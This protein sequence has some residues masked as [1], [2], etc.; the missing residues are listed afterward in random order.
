MRNPKLLSLLRQGCVVQ[1]PLRIRMA[2]FADSNLIEVG[3]IDRD[4]V[5]DKEIFIILGYRD[6]SEEGLERALQD[7][8]EYAERNC[9]DKELALQ[10]RKEEM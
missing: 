8:E 5:K 6:L 3:Y 2:A 7:E 1:F 9:D 4:N 10:E